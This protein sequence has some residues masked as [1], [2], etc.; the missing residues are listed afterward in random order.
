MIFSFDQVGK[1][2]SDKNCLK[3]KK[4]LIITKYNFYFFIKKNFYLA[5]FI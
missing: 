3:I 4:F 1:L 5:K 2:W